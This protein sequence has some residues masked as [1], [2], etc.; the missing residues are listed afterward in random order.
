MVVIY[1]FLAFVVSQQTI[2]SCCALTLLVGLC[3]L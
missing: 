1:L 3:S 2:L